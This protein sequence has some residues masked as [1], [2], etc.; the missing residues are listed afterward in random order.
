MSHCILGL[1]FK[2]SAPMLDFFFS[3]KY[4]FSMRTAVITVHGSRGMLES[5]QRRCLPHRWK[6]SLLPAPSWCLLLTATPA[7]SSGVVTSTVT[8]A[9]AST[10]D[11]AVIRYLSFVQST[12]LIKIK[13]LFH[14]TGSPSNYAPAISCGSLQVFQ[15]ALCW[16]SPRW[17]HLHLWGGPNP[18][19]PLNRH[20]ME[21]GTQEPQHWSLWLTLDC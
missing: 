8:E 14:C 13:G 6:R 3:L 7:V 19:W 10:A 18:W 20:S 15:A 21:G 4:S 16:V 17:Q 9:V 1:T 12:V 11:P 5:A 2:P